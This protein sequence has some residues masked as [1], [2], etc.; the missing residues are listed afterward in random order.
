MF[1]TRT[2]AVNDLESDLWRTA[3]YTS[4]FARGCGKRVARFARNGRFR[5]RTGPCGPGSCH[6]Y[7]VNCKREQLG[8]IFF[9]DDSDG[10]GNTLENAKRTA[11]GRRV[12]VYTNP[13]VVSGPSRSTF[14]R[15][16]QKGACVL[17]VAHAQALL[18]SQSSA[19]NL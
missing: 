1:Y 15:R 8:I 5:T 2:R 9:F 18:Y 7:Y 17:I 4:D 11:D 14:P 10:A 12:F 6:G 16:T 13:R 19:D 3:Y